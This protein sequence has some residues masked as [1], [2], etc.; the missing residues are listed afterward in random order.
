MILLSLS[1]LLGFIFQTTI[2][3]NF[4]EVFVKMWCVTKYIYTNIKCLFFAENPD[5]VVQG[6][7]SSFE[8]QWFRYCDEELE[9]INTFFAGRYLLYSIL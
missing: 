4:K 5:S 8:E 9:K 3:D 1:F 7:F 6:H 2:V